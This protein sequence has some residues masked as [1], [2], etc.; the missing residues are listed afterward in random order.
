MN[1]LFIFITGTFRGA[2]SNAVGNSK[3]FEQENMHAAY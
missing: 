2:V 3:D 1:S